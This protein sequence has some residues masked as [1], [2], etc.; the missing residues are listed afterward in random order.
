MTGGEGD[1][2]MI[3]AVG[4]QAA[5]GISLAACAGLRAFLPLFVVG[6]AGRMDVIPL[7]SHFNWLEGTPALVVLGVAVVTEL[8]ADKFPGVDNLLDGLQT[9]VKPIAG[10]VLMAS[11]LTDLGPLQSAV[12]SLIVGGSVA[13]GVHAAKAK[14]RLISS[15]TT[16]G[17]AN[18]ILSFAEDVG[19]FV[20]SLTALIAPLLVA[21]VLLV[22]LAMVLLL[23]RRRRISAQR[24]SGP[25]AV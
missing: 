14:A 12:L 21:L 16:V 3:L 19:A 18:P 9:L 13:G 20:G 15:A 10:A 4:V 1:W 5:M 7:T 2:G 17:T 25:V 24:R 6:A 22:G 11:V 8:L 23:Y